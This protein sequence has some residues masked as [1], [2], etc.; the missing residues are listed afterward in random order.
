MG[1]GMCLGVQDTF[2]EKKAFS[3]SR[4]CRDRAWRSNLFVRSI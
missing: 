2:I 4:P 1:G 3:S